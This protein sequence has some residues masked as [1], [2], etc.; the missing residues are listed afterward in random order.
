MQINSGFGA[1]VL[2][3]SS[4]PHSYPSLQGTFYSYYSTLR[5]NAGMVYVGCSLCENAHMLD[6]AAVT[7]TE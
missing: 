1:L 5:P 2:N 7:T 4:K 6:V 3:T